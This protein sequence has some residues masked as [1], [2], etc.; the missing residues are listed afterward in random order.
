[1]SKA[2]FMRWRFVII[3]PL[4]IFS[5]QFTKAQDTTFRYYPEFTKYYMLN[6]PD[7]VFA[8]DTT[9]D[10]FHRFHPVEKRFAWLHLGYLGAPAASMY[11]LPFTDP[12]IDVGF[13]QFD[14]YWRRME[15]VKFYDTREPYTSF[16]YQQGSRS[17]VRAVIAHAQNI[18]PYLSIGIDFNRMRTTGWYMRQESKISNFNAFG[19]FR[20]PDNRYNAVFAY[21]LNDLKLQQNG[22][23]VDD[24]LFEDNSFFNKS[25]VSVALQAA[26][27]RWKN[28]EIMMINAVNIGKWIEPDVKDTL[29]KRRIDPVFR[30]QH[31]FGWE[32]RR[33]LFLDELVDSSFYSNPELFPHGGL[34][35]S[36]KVNRILNEVKLLKI[37]RDTADKK[38]R[39]SSDVFFRYHIFK[40]HNRRDVEDYSSAILGGQLRTYIFKVVRMQATGALNLAGRNQGDYRLTG[41]FTYE[42]VPGRKI[43]GEVENAA[44]HPSLMQ[45]EYHS[46]FFEWENDFGQLNFFNISGAYVDDKL[47][48][49][50]KVAAW[51]QSNYIYW[52]ADATPAQYGDV[53]QGMQFF[54]QKNF[55]IGR[56]HL[57]NEL[58]Y[59]TF[60]NDS[61]V[62]FPD[63]VIRSSFYYRNELFNKSVQTKIGFD[64]RYNTDYHA[65]A[66]QPAIGQ[67]PIQNAELSYYPEF[68]VF[69]NVKIK[70]VRAFLELQNVMQ[71]LF[72]NGHFYGYRYPMPDRAFK[73]GFQWMFWN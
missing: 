2:A 31:R 12:D 9:I 48:M 73:V 28:D 6:Q 25:L 23:V 64:V 10:F 24:S 33:Y 13:H 19:R 54:L 16:L 30:L 29:S 8:L 41:V 69:L 51:S 42:F 62:S 18:T 55:R 20:T 40:T 37:A 67:F 65:P 38:F 66:Y 7:T 72:S 63:F 50:L 39:F 35:D 3:L 26:E 15:D 47:Q 4:V 53:L 43:L 45:E 36:V 44:T 52:Q 70:S 58:L 56:V 21:V 71:G 61:I 22:G 1:M 5:F 68:D 60:S 14:P 49:V 57:D 32:R 34:H 11:F 46:V 27:S 59:Q 17:E